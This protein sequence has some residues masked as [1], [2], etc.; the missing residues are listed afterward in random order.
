MHLTAIFREKGKTLKIYRLKFDIRQYLEHT[1]F[2]KA[3]KYIQ[4]IA[5][6]YKKEE[7]QQDLQY[8]KDLVA[9]S[10]TEYCIYQVSKMIW[11]FEI[12]RKRTI[13]K[14]MVDFVKTAKN[15]YYIM[16]IRNIQH[17]RAKPENL[18]RY[19]VRRLLYR[20]EAYK[21][22]HLRQ[23]AYF[24]VGDPAYYSR[25][26]A[27]KQKQLDEIYER[28]KDEIN[29]TMKVE[30]KT[31]PRPDHAFKVFHPDFTVGLT[32]IIEGRADADSASKALKKLYYKDY[33]KKGPLKPLRQEEVQKEREKALRNHQNYQRRHS[34]LWLYKKGL[35]SLGEQIYQSPFDLG[36][37]L[38]RAKS[39]ALLK[40]SDYRRKTERKTRLKRML[41]NNFMA[42]ECKKIGENEP[43]LGFSDLR[44]SS[45]EESSF[46]TAIPFRPGSGNSLLRKSQSSNKMTRFKLS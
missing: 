5:D 3:K 17:S 14:I 34:K 30:E 18:E 12:F 23:V 33:R 19:E 36:Q 10:P 25:N 27:K 32:D 15:D 39:L 6:N 43:T 16:N 45:M 42:M 41:L 44:L 31:D 2:K 4:S 28:I 9:L 35:P 24:K 7:V 21:N 46:P 40:G 1:Q 29:L 20:D 13:N 38:K 26:V 8:I 11:F 37:G 22:S